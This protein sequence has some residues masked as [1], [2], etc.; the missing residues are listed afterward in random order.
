MRN[1]RKYSPKFVL[2]SLSPLSA[3]NLRGPQRIPMFL[4]PKCSLQSR[5]WWHC[6]NVLSLSHGKNIKTSRH[7]RLAVIR[8]DTV[9]S[10]R[11]VFSIALICYLSCCFSLKCYTSLQFLSRLYRNTMF[12][13]QWWCKVIVSVH[14]SPW[15]NFYNKQG[16]LRATV[17]L[18]DQFLQNR[19]RK[20]WSDITVVNI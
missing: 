5:H 7:E 19:S 11:A 8:H 14:S 4:Y 1:S 16:A 18:P 3:L 20:K 9:R 10:W 2:L 12:S 17:T 6:C 13:V 15:R